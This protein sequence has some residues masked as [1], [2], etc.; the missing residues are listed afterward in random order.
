MSRTIGIGCVD[1]KAA[2][3]IEHFFPGV[4]HNTGRVKGGPP[5]RSSGAAYMRFVAA[6]GKQ[7]D[8][9]QKL[10]PIK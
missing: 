1:A 6:K 8:V 2:S 7:R 4:R 5:L 3:S 10:L 9:P